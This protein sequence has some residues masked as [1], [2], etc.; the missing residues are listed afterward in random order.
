MDALSIDRVG[1]DPYLCLSEANKV[2]HAAEAVVKY[3]ENNPES[4][5]D[6]PIWAVIVSLSRDHPC[7]EPVNSKKG[8]WM[9]NYFP[10]PTNDGSVTDLQSQ[11]ITIPPE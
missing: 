8:G 7:E 9:V 5:P 3:L 4:L 11:T 10:Q 6:K 2:N 1:G